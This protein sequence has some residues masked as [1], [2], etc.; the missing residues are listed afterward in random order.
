M[1]AFYCVPIQHGGPEHIR[2]RP[3][4][5]ISTNN[6]KKLTLGRRKPG[7]GALEASRLPLNAWK[8]TASFYDVPI[9]NGGSGRFWGLG[10]GFNERHVVESQERMGF[11]RGD[12]LNDAKP[13]P[14]F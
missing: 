11:Y 3:Q 12:P 13:S 7:V 9:Q 10:L 5:K 4:I 6:A 2:C 1:V 8:C 14:R